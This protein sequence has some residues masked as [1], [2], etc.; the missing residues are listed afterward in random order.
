M[1]R[2]QAL[3]LTLLYPEHC[4]RERATREGCDPIES[5]KLASEPASLTQACANRCAVCEYP[6]ARSSAVV[7]L[8]RIR[9]RMTMKAYTVVTSFAVAGLVGLAACATP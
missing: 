8:C 1:Q 9:S 2:A 6:V 7:S 4:R 5:P 3:R